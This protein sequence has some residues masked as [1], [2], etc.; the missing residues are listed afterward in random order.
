LTERS[1]G[2][3]AAIHRVIDLADR[4]VLEFGCG[5]GYEVWLLSHGYGA[6][7]WGVDV[8]E[9]APWPILADDRTH[10]V[11][12]DLTTDE[13]FP[14]ASFDRIVSINV[15][16]HVERPIQALEALHR[17]LRPGGLAWISANLY[18]G[19]LASHRYRDIHFPWPQLLF[20]DDVI[21]AFDRSRGLPVEGAIWVNKLTW[22]QYRHEIDRIGFTIRRERLRTTPIDEPFLRRFADRLGRYPRVDLERDFFEVIL[23]RKPEPAARGRWAPRG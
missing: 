18:R 3:L 8:L 22:E 6:D 19:P 5:H 23:E 4:R 17:I 20:G 21:R 10:F 11:L 2:R 7:A 1:I 12:G 15:L 13:V 14:D 16:E 9:R